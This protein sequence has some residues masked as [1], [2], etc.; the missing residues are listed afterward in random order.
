MMLAAVLNLLPMPNSVQVNDGKLAIDA[1]FGVKMEGYSDP[2]LLRAM[3]RFQQR[4]SQRTGLTFTGTGTPVMIVHCDGQGQTVQG[5]E[6][7]ESYTL[8]VD[9]KQAV[10]RAHTVVGALRGLETLLQLQEGKSF[11]AVSIFDQPRFSWRG[12]LIDVC[13]HWE[14]VEVIK[15][16]LDAMSAA[17][18]N[19][20]HWHLSEDQ[21]FRVESKKYPKLQEMG[22]DGN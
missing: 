12:L 10:L 18:L 9:S 2:R 21:G 7:D 20:F 16:N 14:P 6:E 5:I 11:Q 19:V 1:S 17:K 15:R 22:S 3:N 13:R 8:T 4:L